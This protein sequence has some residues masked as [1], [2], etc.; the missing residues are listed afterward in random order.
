MGI[1]AP[2]LGPSFAHRGANAQA[3]AAN[4]TQ[5]FDVRSREANFRSDFAGVPRK[6]A[7]AETLSNDSEQRETLLL[8][9][10][11]CLREESHSGRSVSA[12][13]SRAIQL[14]PTRTSIAVTRKGMLGS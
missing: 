12:K 13:S 8:L 14:M 4:S 1:I 7:S 9:A 5:C 11:A 2:L 3:L 6:R 10:K